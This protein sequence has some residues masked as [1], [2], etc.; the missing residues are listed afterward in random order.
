EDLTP[1]PEA[2]ERE[3]LE[4]QFPTRRQ[5][6]QRA[7]PGLTSAKR[8]YLIRITCGSGI[9]VLGKK[10]EWRTCGTQAPEK[11]LSR[12]NVSRRR[13]S[14][15][16]GQTDFVASIVAIDDNKALRLIIE[17]HRTAHKHHHPRQQFCPVY[18]P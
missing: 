8:G 1:R 14:V 9:S 17:C 18:V 12:L 4:L 16:P 2:T 11:A 6:R 7:P 13:S 3:V 10:M 5:H 15:R